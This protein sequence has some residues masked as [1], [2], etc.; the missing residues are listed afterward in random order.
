MVALHTQGQAI[1][2]EPPSAGHTVY[3]LSDALAALTERHPRLQELRA[4]LDGELAKV[5]SAETRFDPSLELKLDLTDERV[6]VQD[7]SGSVRPFDTQ[8]L[9]AEAALQK[10]LSWGGQLRLSL[11][12]SRLDTDNPFRSCVPGVTSDICFESR[13]QLQL[14]QPLLRGR[15]AVNESALR[16][17]AAVKSAEDAAQQEAL[18]EL[19]LSVAQG[20][21]ALAEAEARERVQTTSLAQ[22]ERRLEEGELRVEAGVLAAGELSGLRFG[23]AQAKRALSEARRV[24]AEASAQLSQLTH[25][26]PSGETEALSAV[27]IPPDAPLEELPSMR[28]F[29]FQLKALEAEQLVLEDALKSQLDLGLVWSQSGLGVESG[30]ALRQLPQNQSRFYGVTLSY[31]RPLSNRADAELRVIRARVRALEAQRSAEFVRLRESRRALRIQRDQQLRLIEESE[32]AVQAATEALRFEEE[33]FQAGR[34]TT[35]SLRQAEQ[36]RLQAE[37]TLR[38]SEIEKF[39][40]QLRRLRFAGGLLASFPISSASAS[41]IERALK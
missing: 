12:Q 4:R 25:E 38:G 23:V 10:P 1:A 18:E 27:L 3:R 16:Q 37:L 26:V 2:A 33:R 20:Y 17:A 28:R 29:H 7:M 32:A 14:T 40:I 35:T 9:S 6:T 5:E 34:S 15:G 36:E 13:L 22:S 24:R 31:Q 21:A 11:N 39:R 8:R 19:V 41:R 30:E